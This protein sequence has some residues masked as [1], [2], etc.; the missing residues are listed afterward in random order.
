[1][2][3]EIHSFRGLE[4]TVNHP[5]A[6]LFEQFLKERTF[7]KNVTPATLIW[8]QVAFKNYRQTLT[9]DSSALPTKSSLQ[10]F[11]I[12]LRERGVRPVTVNTYI[13]AMNAFCRW[14]HVEKHLA[15]P[16]RLAKLLV[17]HRVLAVLNDTQLRQLLAFKPKTFRQARTH[18][19][20]AVVLDCG[21][22][23]SE[24]LN[25]KRT[26]VDLD[27]LL[28]KTFGKGRKERLVPFSPE[29][30]KR[31]YR[32]EQLKAKKNVGSEFVFAGF[33]GA[34]WEKR[35]SS[36]SLYL[37]QDKMGLERFGWHRLRH[38]FATN[39]LRQGGDIVRLS[40]VLG[41]TKITTTQRYLHLLTEDLSASHQKVSILNRLG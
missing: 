25:L 28:L 18:L 16:L 2:P 13:A 23:V 10:H 31:L 39:Y 1:V 4:F 8:Y 27:N 15:E 37:L 22:R 14:L 36:T 5:L 7:L 34:K 12:A 29:L 17:E 33:G 38:T 30:R 6:A 19:A 26:E 20:V 9:G 3:N 40:I 21:L 32:F 41:H 11:V 24:L 35:N